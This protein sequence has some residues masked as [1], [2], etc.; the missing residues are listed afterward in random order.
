MVLDYLRNDRVQ[1]EIEDKTIA[2]LFKFELKHWRIDTTKD[3][4]KILQEMLS[5]PPQHVPEKVLDKWKELG[6]LNLDQL[7]KDNNVTV[8]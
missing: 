4:R 5:T 6:P 3:A 2:D 7:T 8:D 1:F